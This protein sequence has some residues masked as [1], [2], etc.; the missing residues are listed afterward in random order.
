MD[1]LSKFHIQLTWRPT[2]NVKFQIAFVSLYLI[3]DCW[4]VILVEGHCCSN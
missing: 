4:Y 2:S 1:G 3:I